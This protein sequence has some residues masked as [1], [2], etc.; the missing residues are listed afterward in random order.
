MEIALTYRRAAPTGQRSPLRLDS[1]SDVLDAHHGWSATSSGL[2]Y[3]RATLTK[4]S[5]I[6]WA[7]IDGREWLH[8]RSGF[9]SQR[10]IDGL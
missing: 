1:V 6:L 10:L 4:P 5:K 2:A 8:R 9:L 3:S 7:K